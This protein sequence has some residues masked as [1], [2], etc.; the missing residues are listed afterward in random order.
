VL[1]KRIAQATLQRDRSHKHQEERPSLRGPR[2]SLV[3]WYI[4][5]A[6]DLGWY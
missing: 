3:Q 1:V 6:R 4:N 2:S 5:V